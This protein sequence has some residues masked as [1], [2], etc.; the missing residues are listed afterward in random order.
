VTCH[1]HPGIAAGV[2][3]LLGSLSVDS[4]WANGSNEGA[5]RLADAESEPP[6]EPVGLQEITVTAQRRAE[7]SQQVPIAINTVSGADLQDRGAVSVETLS[8]AIPN[9]TSTGSFNANMFIRGVGSSSTSPNVEPSVATYVD[10]V[11]MPSQF[12]MSGF[13]FNNIERLEVL[14]GPQG[15]LFGRNA[16]AGVVQIVTPDPKQE[17][18]GNVMLGYGN[19]DTADGSAYLTGGITDK[20]AADLSLMYEGERA[21]YGRNLTYDTN[22]FTYENTA[23]RSKWLYI[24]SDVTRVTV[25]LD[26][27]QYHSDGSNNQLLPGSYAVDGVTTYPGEYNAYGTLNLNDYQQYGASVRIDQDIGAVH[28]ASITAYRNESGQW[29][30]DNDLTSAPLLAVAEY[31]DANYVTQE[32]QLSNK[33][34]GRITWLAGAFFYGNQVDVAPQ[35]TFGTKVANGYSAA[36]GLQSTRSASGFGQATTEIFADTKLTLGLR[37]T[38]ETLHADTARA[39]RAG[40]VLGGP[41]RGRINFDPWTWRAALD[42]QFTSDVL[43]YVS[44]NRGFK[45]GGYNLGN[46][47]T[48]AFLPETLDAYETGLKSEFLDHRVRL[49]LA[50]FNYE[51]KNIQVA[52]AP[53]NGT[54]IFTNAAGARNYGLDGSLDFAATDN[55]TFSAGLGLL[56]ARYTDYPNAIGFTNRGVQ[57]LVPNAKGQSL[58]YAPPVTGFVSS[59]YRV[60][61]SIGEFSGTANLSYNDRSYISPTESP[62]RPTYFL[63]SSSV[64]WWSKAANAV[65]V[66]LWGRNLTNAYYPRNLLSSANGWY[67]S[68]APPRTYGLMLLMKF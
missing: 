7:N 49:N 41:Y 26:W 17:F 51:Y 3:S 12:G 30:V 19:Y 62:E 50:V 22:I 2:L 6:P 40:T 37:Y 46:P 39:D 52:I 67:Q 64:E 16:T 31:N 20:L 8:T 34:P 42:H 60:P 11:Y 48:A 58:P 45:S 18:S 59:S 32:F 38:D 4:T 68:P 35:A 27:S 56:D 25:A 47:G 33:N 5:I 53:G 15:T 29:V 43:G 14:K 63:L 24:P 1:R 55:L 61:T 21:G 66:R 23:A 65:G 54:Q 36:Y 13:A 9:L 28:G 44:Y 57:I 10:G